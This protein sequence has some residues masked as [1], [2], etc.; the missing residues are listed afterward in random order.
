MAT[1]KSTDAR[2]KELRNEDPLSGEAGS[3][4][5]GVGV[6]ATLGGAAAGALAGAVG[7]PI[8]AAVGAI[9]GG[10][11]GGYAGKAVAES[12]DP[13]VE[14]DHWRG[15]YANR[16]YYDESRDFAEYEPAYR[17]GLE[18]YDP[19]EPS[20]WEVRE[21]AAKKC[22]AATHPDAPLTWAEARPAAQDAYTRVHNNCCS[23]PR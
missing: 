4:P 23:K 18:A 21:A 9:A 15:E 22:Y 5:V 3:H 7:G 12:V 19:A 10:V 1:N 6:G 20:T 14:I 8:G 11:A 2:V 16:P 13:T 17:A